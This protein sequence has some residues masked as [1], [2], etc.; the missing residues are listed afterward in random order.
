MPVI[1]KCPAEHGTIQG[2]MDLDSDVLIIEF[3]KRRIFR[4]PE[5]VQLDIPLG[6]ID[7]A[8]YKHWFIGGR[9]KIR[10][11][12][13]DSARQIPWRKSLNVDFV[14]PRRLS[15]S[16]RVSRRRSTNLSQELIR[17]QIYPVISQPRV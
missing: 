3:E 15:S 4:G 13:L 14:I 12:Y 5:I 7:F 6:D 1:F 10:T 11:L 2:V 8:E 17:A 16:P 9:L